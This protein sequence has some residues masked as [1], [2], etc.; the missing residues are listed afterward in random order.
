MY[1]CRQVDSFVEHELS[2][3][4]FENLFILMMVKEVRGKGAKSKKKQIC[5][6]DEQTPLTGCCTAFAVHSN[7]LSLLE[8]N[9]SWIMCVYRRGLF[10]LL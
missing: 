10:E 4:I 5:R 1:Y 9:L 8:N 6:I 2:Q 3:V 7:D